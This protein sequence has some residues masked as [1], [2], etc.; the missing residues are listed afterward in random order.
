MSSSSSK[1]FGIALTDDGQ[2]VMATVQQ[3]SGARPSVTYK[4]WPTHQWFRSLMLMHRGVACGLP[5]YWRL[6][7]D[8]TIND[9]DAQHFAGQTGESFLAPVGHVTDFETHRSNLD[10]NLTRVL[11][12]DVF[13]ATLPAVF[14]TAQKESFITVYA[15]AN[16]FHIGVCINRRYHG[17]FRMAPV[18]PEAVEGHLGRIQRKF[19][20]ANPSLRF[21][22]CLYIIG[23]SHIAHIEG[24]EIHQLEGLPIEDE[25]SMRALGIACAEISPVGLP[26]FQGATERSRF[27]PVRAA[28]YA[29]SVV[30]VALTL[31]AGAAVWE[32]NRRASRDLLQAKTQ[33]QGVLSGNQEIQD[34]LSE[35]RS[36][37]EKILRIEKT[38]TRQT[39]WT[40]LLTALSEGKPDGLFV[41]VVGTNSGNDL[42]SSAQVALAGWAEKER[43]I[44][45]LITYL[46]K[47]PFLSNLD[48]NVIE[49]DKKQRDLF[50]FRLVC[51]LQ[52]SNG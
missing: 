19:F 12:E 21:P 38:L 51:T 2:Y 1:H 33:Y 50:R 36:L 37:S 35:N 44:T 5:A 48:L 7:A 25:P 9:L 13:L 31:I 45:E 43:A 52:L 20:L 34:L 27:R 40:R 6:A 46:Q 47:M 8:G 10:G 3:Q 42:G 23:G 49:Q 4:R 11:P 28:L 32:L 15:T 41:D 39:T 29:A 18:T 17:T 22:K 26:R 30:L 16:A 24:F 14:G